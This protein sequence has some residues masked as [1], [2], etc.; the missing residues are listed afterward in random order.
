MQQ[1]FYVAGQAL[2]VLRDKKLYRETH[3]TFEA[4]IRDRFGFTKAAAYYLI[5]AFEVVNNL[6][7]QPLVDLL[8]TNE[9]Q[10]REIAKLLPDIQPQ[11]WLASVQKANG[12]VPS[13]RIIKEVVKLAV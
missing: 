9:R 4:Y 5:S 13:A 1:A 8:P 10:C 12:K 3:A 6:K 11:A 7:S 2:K